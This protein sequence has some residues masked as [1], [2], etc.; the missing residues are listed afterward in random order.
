MRATAVDA[1][2]RGY[3]VTIPPDSQ[4]GLNEMAEQMTLLTLSAMPPYDPIYLRRSA[5]P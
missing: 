2:Q 4:A 5:P 3:V 1:L